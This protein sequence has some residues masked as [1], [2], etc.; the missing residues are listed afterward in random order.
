MAKVLFIVKEIGLV[1]RLG[2]M[3]LSANLKKH[4]HIVE[5]R[6]G[7][8][9]NF[10]E[11]VRSFS[12]DIVAYSATTGA[13]KYYLELNRRLKKELSFL[14]ILGGP[15]ATFFPEVLEADGLDAV[16]VGEG[17]E[18]IV[19]LANS[20]DANQPLDNIHPCQRLPAQ[21]GSIQPPYQQR[22]C[23]VMWY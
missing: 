2:I 5:L 16:C 22:I 11:E 17:E 15:H 10:L 4:G 20:L 6:R 9:E 14:A 1:E 7:L 8:G 18:P 12:P 21:R 23:V 19:D 3:Y 13:H